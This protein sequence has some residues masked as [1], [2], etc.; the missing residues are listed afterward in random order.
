MY[1]FPIEREIRYDLRLTPRHR[2]MRPSS[3]FFP[4]FSSSASLSGNLTLFVRP[5]WR[6]Y[7]MPP[8]FQEPPFRFIDG[9]SAILVRSQNSILAFLVVPPPPMASQSLLSS[10]PPFPYVPRALFPLH[11]NLPSLP[12][13]TD[14]P[15]ANW[16]DA[17]GF[18][19]L[20][21]VRTPP[22]LRFLA[23]P[24]P[25]SFSLF[26]L[27]RCPDLGRAFF[28][29]FLCSVFPS[30]LSAGKSLACARFFRVTAKAEASGI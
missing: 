30:N 6:P 16:N 13:V 23:P 24:P 3:V 17:S 7:R 12:A 4:S 22:F 20:N 21:P 29:S 5:C 28:T 1:S 27:E 10:P 18:W 9:W 11:V 15:R 26:F 25:F 2:N 8:T 14:P 19:V